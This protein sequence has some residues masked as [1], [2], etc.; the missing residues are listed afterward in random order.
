M[1]DELVAGDSGGAH[2]PRG[3]G[4]LDVH[5]D[6]DVLEQVRDPFDPVPHQV[7]AHVVGVEVGGEHPDTAH[8]VGGEDVEE[9]SDVVGGV[10]DDRLACSRSPIR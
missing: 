10:H 2:H 5:G 1:L 6:L 9:S 8:V 3:L 7:A 4:S